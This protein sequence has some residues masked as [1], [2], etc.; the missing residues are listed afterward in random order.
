MGRWQAITFL[1]STP[2]YSMSI[3]VTCPSCFKRFNVSDQFAGKS[4]P[5]PNCKKPIKIPDKSEQVVI[6][7]PEEAGPKDSK[8]RSVLRPIRRKEVSLSLPV[9]MAAALGTIVVFGVALGLGLSGG[10][11]TIFLALSSIVLA[12]PIAFVGYW[13]LHDDELEGYTGKSLLIRSAICAL[14]M[15]ATWAIY[16]FVPAYLFEDYRS[17][18]DIDGLQMAI[19]IGVM[20]GLGTVA[21]I[22][23]FELEF[24]Q[25]MLHYM[26][27][28][29]LTFILAWLSG[30]PLGRPLVGDRATVPYTAPAISPAT[31]PATEPR[32]TPPAD[33]KP[34][35]AEDKP[36]NIPKILQ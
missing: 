26:F 17:T 19:L 24:V 27:Y 8:G 7:A 6:H 5:C 2:Q 22:L 18:A 33:S 28:F 36:E 15:A 16:V 21:S 25:G 23:I 13:F 12:A 9:I 14:A 30:V 32:E 1:Q 34:A 4:G 3:P 31:P 20:I 10:A 29:V 35:P 11:P